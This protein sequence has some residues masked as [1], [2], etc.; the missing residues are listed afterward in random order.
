MISVIVPIYNVEYYLDECLYS[1][2]NQTYRDIEILCINDCTLDNSINTVKKYMQVD[3]RIRLINHKENRG[4]GGARNTGIQEAKGE[5][6]AFV[7]SDDVLNVTTLE[8][9]IKAMHDYDVDAVV[10]GISRFVEKREI[11]RFSTFHNLSNPKTGIYSLK[12]YKERTSDMWPSAPNKLYKTSIIRQYACS[13]PEKILYEDHFFFYSYFAHVNSFY[14]INEPLYK[15]RASRDGSI[16]STITGREKEVFKVLSDLESIF[17]RTLGE[18]W[19]RAY[20]KICF[21]LIWERTCLLWQNF[22][23]WKGFAK[24]SEVWLLNRFDSKLLQ[25]S[26]DSSINHMDPFYRYMFTVG[27]SK[28]LFRIKLMLKG[29]TFITKLHNVYKQLKGYRTT[30]S[31]VKELIWLCWQNKE[32]MQEWNYP[33]W[34]SHDQIDAL[35]TQYLMK[36]EDTVL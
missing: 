27:T 6:I 16:T 11:A 17:Q 23:E 9:W 7:D 8:K 12:E 34:H 25:S 13:F 31:Y 3:R 32:K 20:A 36:N 19:N 33:I 10:C 22:P 18:T 4:L 26:V 15:Y 30:R 14:Y 2:V 1:I 24:E 35:A 28:V 5:Y 21:R 29:K